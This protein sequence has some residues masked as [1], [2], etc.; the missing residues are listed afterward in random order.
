MHH[1]II[2]LKIS[3]N[4]SEQTK[5]K[6]QGLERTVDVFKN[7]FNYKKNYFK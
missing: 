2:G 5:K 1:T 7:I 3:F 6:R 4:G